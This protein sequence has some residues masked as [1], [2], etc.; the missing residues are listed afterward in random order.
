MIS[1][2]ATIQIGYV[3]RDLETAHVTTYA[4]SSAALEDIY[5]LAQAFVDRIRPLTDAKARLI[6]IT[7]KF[8][9]TGG[10]LLENIDK[11]RKLL[12]LVR[13]TD[14]ELSAIHMPWPRDTIFEQTGAYTGIRIDREHPDI[15]S[16]SDMLSLIDFRNYDGRPLGND[17]ITGGLML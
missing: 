7:Y 8:T 9:F 13:N 15:V 17:L 10:S 14:D 3:D 6:T 4:P 16:F 5:S 12:L 1:P 11:N 2:H